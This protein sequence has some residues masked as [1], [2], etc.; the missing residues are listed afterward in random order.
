MHSHKVLDRIGGPT[1][2]KLCAIFLNACREEELSMIMN[3]TY[4]KHIAERQSYAGMTA[5]CLS[6]GLTTAAD[7]FGVMLG[8]RPAASID[9]RRIRQ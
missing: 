7:S 6:D 4:R 3:W 9:N 2:Y 8:Q 5:V 1:L